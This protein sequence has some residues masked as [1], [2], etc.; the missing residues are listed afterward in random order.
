MACSNLLS[1]LTLAL[2]SLVGPLLVPLNTSVGGGFVGG[3]GGGLRGVDPRGGG[4]GGLDVHLWDFRRRGGPGAGPGRRRELGEAVPTR[5][6]L[7]RA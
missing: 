1:M 4:G 3:G 7:S 5:S 6:A 2:G